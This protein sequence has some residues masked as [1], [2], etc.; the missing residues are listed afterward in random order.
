[1]REYLVAIGHPQSGK[2]YGKDMAVMF[3]TQQ[4]PSFLF[5][6]LLFHGNENPYRAQGIGAQQFLPGS[7]NSFA[8]DLTRKPKNPK[9]PKG[10]PTIVVEID[11]GD[12]WTPYARLVTIQGE[13]LSL[14]ARFGNEWVGAALSAL[15]TDL[16]DGDEAEV[17]V[18][19]ER[20]ST[21]QAVRLQYS[22]MLYT[23]P[24]TWRKFMAE[25]VSDSGLFG[26]FYI[27]GSELT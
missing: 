18:T 8:D 15:V 13:A 24:G 4:S 19:S 11:A 10:E 25:T 3:Y 26:R 6:P 14:L 17:A 1:M 7:P 16:Y 2:S 5:E 27:L 20:G 23:Q 21:K 9:A 22:M 12:T